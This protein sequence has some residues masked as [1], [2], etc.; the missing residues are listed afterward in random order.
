LAFY[1]DSIQQ[2]TVARAKVLDEITEL[3]G[4]DIK[5]RTIGGEM[6]Y[7]SRGEVQ[8]FPGARSAECRC[9]GR[10]GRVLHLIAYAC[11]YMVPVIYTRAR[12]PSGDQLR[13]AQGSTRS[14][15]PVASSACK[16]SVMS[17]SGTG[18]YTAE[19]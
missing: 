2:E 14:N 16:Y 17:A 19:T 7:H 1:R 8:A 4:Y 6:R 18:P 3:F 10:D 12:V 9:D 5:A 13:P 11:A 15:I